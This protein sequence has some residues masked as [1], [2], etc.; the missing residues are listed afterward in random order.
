MHV[1]EGGVGCVGVDA[2]MLPG[3]CACVALLVQHAT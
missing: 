2:Q 3:A 1:G